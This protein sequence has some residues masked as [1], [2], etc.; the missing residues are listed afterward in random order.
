MLHA[1]EH[2]VFEGTHACVRVCTRE[3]LRLMLDALLH[4]SPLCA[5]THGLSLN[6]ELAIL[7][8][9]LSQLVLESP[10]LHYVLVEM[11]G[12]PPY[13]PGLWVGLWHQ[14]KSPFSCRTSCV[15]SSA[16]VL[17]H[18]HPFSHGWL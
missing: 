8:S 5:F 10:S 7:A 2:S 16:G 1:C 6:L 3:G 9:L 11:T 13:S 18:Y 4:G 12:R 17:N 14:N 15:I